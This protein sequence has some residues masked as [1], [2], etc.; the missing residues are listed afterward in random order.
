MIFKIDLHTHT[1]RYS[2]CSKLSPQ[3]LCET[4]IRRGLDAIVITEHNVQ[5]SPDEIANLQD[6]YPALKL[7]AGVEISVDDEH[8]Y[9]VIGLPADRYGPSPT[10]YAQFK[11][12][13]EAHPNAF[14][15]L[16]HCF[17]YSDN[18]TGLADKPIEGFELGNWN[19]LVRPQPLGGPIRYNRFELYL[20]WQR[21]MSWIALYN[22]DSHAEHA[23][24][25]F[26]N[27][28]E[29]DPIPPDEQSLIHL[30]RRG[31]IRGCQNDDL[32]RK[33]INSL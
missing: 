22:S 30:L 11:T 16:A 32:I 3:S 15:F 5:W 4:A 29:T 21:Q 28:I 6:Q 33:S 2:T 24:G 27:Q 26:Y 12:L 18:E 14:A 17:R 7:Y 8:H 9:G 31:N 1:N 20:K 13:M 10:P 23:V 19:M 25:T